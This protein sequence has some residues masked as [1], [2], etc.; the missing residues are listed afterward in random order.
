MRHRMC[1]IAHSSYIRQVSGCRY[2]IYASLTEVWIIVKCLSGSPTSAFPYPHLPLFHL[3]TTA[4]L[5]APLARA[6][7]YS[8]EER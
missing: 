6:A 4:L 3:H 7:R 5:P 1:L 2:F 8:E